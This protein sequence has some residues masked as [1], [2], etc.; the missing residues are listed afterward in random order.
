MW[1]AV[2]GGQI[3]YLYV[4]LNNS[5]L[6]QRFYKNF[7]EKASYRQLQSIY[8]I[9]RLR[10]WLMYPP[11]PTCPFLA[12]MADWQETPAHEYSENIRITITEWFEIT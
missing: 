9:S 2:P 7:S 12:P 4:L 10:R 1:I 3:H 11:G 6:N 5:K 8:K